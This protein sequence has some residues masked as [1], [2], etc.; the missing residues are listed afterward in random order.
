MVLEVIVTSEMAAVVAAD[1]FAAAAALFVSAYV[2]L[3]P[4]VRSTQ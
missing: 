2:R 3:Q 1:S 4:Q